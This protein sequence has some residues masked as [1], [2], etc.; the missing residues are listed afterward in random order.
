LITLTL[1]GNGH[2]HAQA[3][4]SPGKEPQ[5]PLDM[6]LEGA[7][8]GEQKMLTEH[9]APMTQA[10][11]ET[12]AYFQA[13]LKRPIH[14]QIHWAILLC[15]VIP[16]GKNWVNCAVLTGNSAGPKTVLSG[17]L[18]HWKLRRSLRESHSC[19]HHDGIIS[20]HICF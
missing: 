6:W 13:S 5:K 1:D 8:F 19:R 11:R 17:R 20:R 4:L 3:A 12:E 14:S 10:Y 2:L 9:H 15:D 16:D 7:Q 18:S